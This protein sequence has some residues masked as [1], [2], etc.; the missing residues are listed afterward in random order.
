[1]VRGGIDEKNMPLSFSFRSETV[2][3]VESLEL[4]KNCD[5]NG[6]GLLS[7]DNLKRVLKDVDV[8]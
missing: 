8:I 4:F 1:M 2:T 7:H 5:K 6:D 3:D